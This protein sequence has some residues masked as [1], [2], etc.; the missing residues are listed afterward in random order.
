MVFDCKVDALFRHLLLS[1][2]AGGL[3][4][5][6]DEGELVRHVVGVVSE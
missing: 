4:S 6:G 1:G 5:W 2:W 3:E